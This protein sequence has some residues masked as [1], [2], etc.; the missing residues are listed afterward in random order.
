MEKKSIELLKTYNQDII[1]F[2]RIQRSEPYKANLMLHAIDLKRSG[3]QNYEEFMESSFDAG[4]FSYQE[5]TY[6]ERMKDEQYSEFV[7]EMYHTLIVNY[8]FEQIVG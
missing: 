4:M 5:L 6:F 1:I 7:S 3:I 2:D 8:F